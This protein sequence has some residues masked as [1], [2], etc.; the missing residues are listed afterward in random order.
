M[1]MSYHE[2]KISLRD[3]EIQRLKNQLTMKDQEIQR[4]KMIIESAGLGRV[5][6]NLGSDYISGIKIPHSV[7]SIENKFGANLHRKVRCEKRFQFK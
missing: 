1:E 6:R 7:A 2:W 5:L 4:L 3:E